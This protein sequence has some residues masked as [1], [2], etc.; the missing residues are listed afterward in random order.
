MRISILTYMRMIEGI[1]RHNNLRVPVEIYDV[2]VDNESI[3]VGPYYFKKVDL[4][5]DLRQATKA[6]MSGVLYSSYVDILNN[7]YADN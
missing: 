1:S 2:V 7:Y 4:E 5:V 6:Y 3:Q